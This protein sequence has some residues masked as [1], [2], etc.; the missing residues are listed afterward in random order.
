MVKDTDIPLYSEMLKDGYSHED[1]VTAGYFQDNY[2]NHMDVMTSLYYSQYN[3]SLFHVAS[4]IKPTRIVALSGCFSPI[5]AGHISALTKAKEHYERLGERVLGILIP[6]HDSYVDVKRNGTC[7]CSA[8]ERIIK[9]KKYLES[10]QIDWV[11]V[12]EHPA[13]A[14][15]GELNFPYLLTRLNATMPKTK[16]SFVFG[17]DNVE[18]VWAMS[19][20]NFDSFV[21]NRNDSIDRINNA[22]SKIRN[23]YDKVV[24]VEDNEYSD[25]SSTL[26]RK[27]TIETYPENAVYLVRDDSMLFNNGVY[28]HYGKMISQYLDDVFTPLGIRVVTINAEEQ[29][30]IFT[31]YMKEKYGEGYVAI[32]MDKYWKGSFQLNTSRIFEQYSYQKQSKGM[33]Y[34]NISALEKFIA[35][36]PEN[37]N[38]VLVDDDIS[39]GFTINA[40]QE[41]INSIRSDITMTTEFISNVYM[42]HTSVDFTAEQIYDIVDVRDFVFKAANGGLVV[43]QGKKVVRVPYTYPNVNLYTRAK[44]PYNKII[45]FTDYL[46]KINN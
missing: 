33:V 45:D 36:L 28:L 18:F 38:I 27:A 31:K 7:K 3:N 40:I 8:I 30:S 21:V 14:M 19:Y 22:I 42:Q 39:T 9:I 6:A 25:L 4:K 29:L 12:D 34:R 32:S 43:Q 17:A 41:L 16:I 35:K 46:N 1:V 44:I 23:G 5:H 2:T 10:H 24:V 37:A 15:K 26:V 11:V 20:S 13:L